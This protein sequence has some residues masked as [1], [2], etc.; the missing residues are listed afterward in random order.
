MS[1]SG[2]EAEKKKVTRTEGVTSRK[3]R[4]GTAGLNESEFVHR[5]DLTILVKTTAGAGDVAG[6]CTA[7]LGA[8][9]ER[10]RAPALTG[11]PESFFH[12]G[13]SALW[14][15]HLKSGLESG[16]GINGG[17]SEMSTI[18]SPGVFRPSKAPQTPGPSGLLWPPPSNFPAAGQTRSGSSLSRSQ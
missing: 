15:C 18:Q 2:I 9:L 10:R 3:I 8:G 12:F 5:K 17:F 16:A 14:D 11:T 13:G 7:A 1:S 6:D 4:S